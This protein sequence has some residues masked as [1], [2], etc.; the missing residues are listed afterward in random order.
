MKY[1]ILFLALLFVLTACRSTDIVEKKE[2]F[3][4]MSIINE[5][6]QVNNNWVNGESIIITDKNTITKII[7][8]INKSPKTDLSKIVWEHGP[9][10]RIV[11]V[12]NNNIYHEVKAFTS[13]T[14]VTDKYAISAEINFDELIND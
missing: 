6:P 13:G 4:K 1:R 2:E 7:D 8:K 10:L 5:M 12:G 3:I 14:V 11:F 9:D